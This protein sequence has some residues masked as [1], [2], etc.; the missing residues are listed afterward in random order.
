MANPAD[1]S[2]RGQPDAGGGDKPTKRRGVLTPR[3]HASGALPRDSATPQNRPAMPDNAE[4]LAAKQ[5]AVRRDD[6]PPRQKTDNQAARSEDEQKKKN[7][8]EQRA[9]QERHE[10]L[11]EAIKAGDIHSEQTFCELFDVNLLKD[12]DFNT[13]E[14]NKIRNWL[15]RH[16]STP[17]AVGLKEYRLGTFECIQPFQEYGIRWTWPRKG[18][19]DQCVLAVFES[20]KSTRASSATGRSPPDLEESKPSLIDQHPEDVME[21]FTLKRSGPV[22][23][24][25]CHREEVLSEFA[26]PTVEYGEDENWG[27][28]DVVVWAVI[29]LDSIK[30]PNGKPCA[31][32][33]L[34]LG[35]LPKRQGVK[36]TEGRPDRKHNAKHR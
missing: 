8:D 13:E 24:K 3:D 21:T 22:F 6:Q 18:V 31:T 16:F 5:D 7:R 1:D 15:E 11:V 26:P 29:E 17:D 12:M 20:A 4:A 10:K 14:Q 36:K 34:W 27:G 33:G 19:A 35:R 30:T 28:F 23:C 25:P 2:R 32:K 9:R